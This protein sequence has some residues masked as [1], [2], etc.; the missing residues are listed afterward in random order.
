MTAA[1][2]ARP[3]GRRPLTV[4]GVL[5]GVALVLGAA[6]LLANLLARDT[7][8]VRTT[9]ADVRALL[10]EADTGD[11]ELA[12]AP[13]G[14]PLTVEERVT[15]GLTGPRRLNHLAGGRL[16]LRSECRGLLGS[17]CGVRYVIT[18][19]AR[20]SVVAHSGS[21]D[22]DADGL[23]SGAR[24][25]L[26][27]GSGEVRARGVSAPALR[28]QSGAGS[29]GGSALDVP[30]LQA[31]T[32]SGSIALELREPPRT[33]TADS[34]SGDVVLTLPDQPY[35]LTASTGSGHLIDDGVH[36][37]TAS[38]HEVTARSGSGDIVLD[39]GRG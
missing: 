15:R 30:R 16:R 6:W 3:A 31:Q 29:I 22:V 36:Q 20:T 23:D 9:Y 17:Q 38:P 14:A 12:S 19:P 13:A 10:V 11:V 7:R 37:D 34:G 35:A 18:V 27:T 5:A 1:T 4:F 24:I 26:S 39:V 28:L 25:E 2:V 32:G 33:L 8:V 21:G